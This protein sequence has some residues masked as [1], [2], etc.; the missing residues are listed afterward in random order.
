MIVPDLDAINKQ[1]GT[2]YV[3]SSLIVP[4]PDASYA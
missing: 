4:W 2:V 3:S 1:M